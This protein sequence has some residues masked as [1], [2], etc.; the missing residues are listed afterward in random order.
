[1]QTIK[2]K[3]HDGIIIPLE[4]VKFKEN[5]EFEISVLE[6][7]ENSELGSQDRIAK[8]YSEYKEKYPDE[9]V[10]IKDFEYVGIFEEYKNKD[11]KQTLI[12]N[13]ESIYHAK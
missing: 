1:M 12:D 4:P 8:A 2:V 11:L 13:I 7:N 9:Q 6:K 10:N 3:Y 5:E